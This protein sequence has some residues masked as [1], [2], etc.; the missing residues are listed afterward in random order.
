ML[1]F[2][3]TGLVVLADQASK[4]LIERFFFMKRLVVAGPFLAITYA[5]NFGAAF[6]IMPDQT[7]LLIGVT[8]VVLIGTWL[9]RRK[10]ATYPRLF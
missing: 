2:I 4:L 6:G 7:M 10:I 9:G 1:Y 3:L 5:Q 8:I